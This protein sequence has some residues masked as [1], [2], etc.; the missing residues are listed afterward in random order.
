MWEKV[1]PAT[2]ERLEKEFASN[3]ELYQQKKSAE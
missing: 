3:K 1:D 2:K